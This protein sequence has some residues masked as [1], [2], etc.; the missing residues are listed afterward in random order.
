MVTGYLIKMEASCYLQRINAKSVSCF[1][2]VNDASTHTYTR[3][4]T[5]TYTYALA[6]VR[7]WALNGAWHSQV[8]YA[9]P[10]R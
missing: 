7:R 5:R 10:T 4:H 9:R 8:Q 1:S 2:R 6:W 3:T